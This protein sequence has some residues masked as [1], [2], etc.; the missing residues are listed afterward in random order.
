MLLFLASCEELNTKRQSAATVWERIETVYFHHGVA[1]GP[2]L[3]T[4]ADGTL[5]E[6]RRYEPFGQPVNANLGGTIGPVD[7]RREQ[8]NSLGKLTNPNTGW[9]YH[10]ARWMQPQTARWTA[11]D[12]AVKGPRE[13]AISRPAALNPY[14]YVRQAPTLFWD[15]DGND[16]YMIIVTNRPSDNAFQAAASTRMREI[17][18][19]P[20]FDPE[21]DHVYMA[22]VVD[23]GNLKSQVET[24]VRDAGDKGYGKTVSFEHFGHHGVDHGPIGDVRPS[25][26]ALGN[27]ATHQIT[28][29]AW[30][31]IN[32]NFDPERSLAVFHG[33]NSLQFARVF[34]KQQPDVNAVAGF[35]SWSFPSTSQRYRLLPDKLSVN[36]DVYFIGGEHK[37][38]FNRYF[39]EQSGAPQ[40][41]QP[42]TV[43][44]ETDSYQT[45]TNPNPP[46]VD[47]PD[48]EVE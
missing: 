15:A 8:Q 19:S 3:T 21:T 34:G 39:Q 42:M 5:R 17:V 20:T 18:G 45:Y 37:W 4:N 26:S 28:P 40:W 7:F 30:G 44:S 14:A 29:D 33:C 22:G 32:F 31:Q 46:E 47:F 35:T 6:E 1:A 41:A 27:G 43:E 36:N 11:P 38:S 2:V 9:S 16:V 23:L 25:S 13:D 12:P 10:G 48:V 24:W